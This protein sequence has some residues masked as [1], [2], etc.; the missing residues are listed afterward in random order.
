MNQKVKEILSWYPTINDKQRENLLKII[1]FGRIKG[2]GKFVIL[3]VDQG[4]EHGPHRSF[5]LNPAGFDPLYHAELAVKSGCNAYAAPLG[6]IE[7]GYETIEK[8]ALP[9]IL[10]VNNHDLMMPDDQDPFPAL[11]AWVDDAVRLK[12]VGVGITIYP[13]SKHAREMYQQVK[14][15]AT[16]AY[17]AGIIVVVW[18]YPRGSGL[19][20]VEAETAVDVVSYGVQ[21]ACQLGAH[22]IKCK[23][24]KNII[25]LESNIKK[26]IFK[27]QVMGTLADRT[28]LVLQAGFDGRR[29]VICSGGDTK[30][31]EEVLEEV[32]QLAMGGALGS[33]VGR[34]SFQRPEQD[35]IELLHDI[36]DIYSPVDIG[37]FK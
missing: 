12:A 35:A 27:G 36:Q 9:I 11:T 8:H 17:K 23:P 4:F 6:A 28:K 5:N 7:A 10:K 14:R 34:N 30:G 2:T 3:P 18:S 25:G 20:S 13:G 32:R 21:I 31:K 1:N 33:I 15:L 16:E 29:I 37:K 22:I 26:E 24:T 19:P